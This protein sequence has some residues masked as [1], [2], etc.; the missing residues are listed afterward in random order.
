MTAV[1]SPPSPDTVDHRRGP[2]A[3][4]GAYLTELQKLRAQLAVRL[5]ALL[6]VLGPFAFA[7][8][9]K[10]Q[11]GTPSDALFG[12]WVHSSGYAISL[13]TLG[14]AGSWGVPIIAGAVAGDLFASE[15]RFSTWKTVLTRS[16][17]REDVFGGKVLAA[18]TVV[19]RG[20]AVLRRAGGE[21]RCGAEGGQEGD[22]ETRV[23]AAV[24]SVCVVQLLVGWVRWV[25]V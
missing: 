16:C 21:A 17:T 13:V 3:V 1:A 10:V 2:G 5:V 20:R 12:A 11:S 8:L 9:L 18:G 22:V 24:C 19:G 14:F 15:D 7:A 6:A 4:G 23:E 25:S